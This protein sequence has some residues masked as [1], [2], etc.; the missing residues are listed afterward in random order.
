M[1]SCSHPCLTLS[2]RCAIRPVFPLLF[3]PGSLSACEPLNSPGLC[4]LTRRLLLSHPALYPLL[5]KGL[6]RCPRAVRQLAGWEGFLV[7]PSPNRPAGPAKDLSNALKPDYD[8][9]HVLLSV[10]CRCV[11]GVV[12]TLHGTLNFWLGEKNGDAH[13]ESGI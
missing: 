12:A 8:V 3:S 6:R 5:N 2:S 4:Y 11:R 7:Y 1:R 9:A 13:P 10:L